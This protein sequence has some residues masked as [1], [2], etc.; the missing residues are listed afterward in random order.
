MKDSVAL[1]C[2]SEWCGGTL[3][4]TPLYILPGDNMLTAVSVARNCGMILPQD[5]VIIAEALPPKDGQ[6]AQ[7]HW[8][9]ADNASKHLESATEV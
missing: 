4:L 2:L 7:I 3:V 9:Y 8:L 1:Y 6:V 5:E